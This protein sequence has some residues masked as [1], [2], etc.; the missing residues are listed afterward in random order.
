MINMPIERK[1]INIPKNLYQ[2]LQFLCNINN[3]DINKKIIKIFEDA[4]FSAEIL[5]DS[6]GKIEQVINF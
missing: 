2:K 1:E 4:I 6:N 3:L 5:K